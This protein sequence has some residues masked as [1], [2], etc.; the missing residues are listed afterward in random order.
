MNVT[1]V[2]RH[3]RVM[4]ITDPFILISI[5]GDDVCLGVRIKSRERHQVAIRFFVDASILGFD[6]LRK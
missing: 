3:V 2:I 6:D 5:P 4:I 1:K